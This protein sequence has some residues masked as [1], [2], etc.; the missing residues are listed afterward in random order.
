MKKNWIIGI[1]IFLLASNLTLIATLLIKQ[2][3]IN[4][5]DKL[6]NNKPFREN[7]QNDRRDER[8]FEEMLAGD[9]KL[10]DDQVDKLHSLGTDFHHKRKELKRVMDQLKHEY[11]TQLAVNNPDEEM[12]HELADSLGNLLAKVVL[13]EYNH[14]QDIKSICTPEQA[15]KLD[16]L[17]KLHIHK[18]KNKGYQRRQKYSGNNSMN[19]F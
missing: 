3:R 6:V 1:I 14:Y 8:K 16:S 17:G 11:F 19:N 9:L 15:H 18:Y 12:L 5:A 2:N 7:R 10:S 4:S 13:L